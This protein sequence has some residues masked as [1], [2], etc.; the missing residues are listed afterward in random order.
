MGGR[1]AG[2]TLVEVLVVIGVIGVLIGLTLPAVQRARASASRVSCQNRLKQVGVALQN[3]HAAHGRLPPLPGKHSPSP[4]L[5][6]LLGWMAHIL[7]YID[8]D[9]LFRTSE[10]ACRTDPN[11]FHNPPHVGLA[12]IIPAYVCPDDGRLTPMTDSFGVTAAYTSYIGVNGAFVP[13]LGR[14]L[15]GPFGRPLTDVADGTSQ[16]LLVGERPPPDSLQA[17][18]WYPVYA[19][20]GEGFRGPNS[21]MVVNDPIMFAQDYEC[22][23]A[24]R[25]HFGPGR[26]DN[27]CDRYHFWSLHPGGA[28]WLFVD[29][30][31]R[32][33]AYSADPIIAALATRAGGETVEMPN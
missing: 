6:A 33:F 27:P 12:T 3:T 16:T 26:L 13:A 15:P 4:D 14:A 18:W 19:G 24:W 8:Q 17:G 7:P 20:S 23:G 11:P 29:G 1:R 30:S 28:N 21:F 9:A 25:G 5:Y 2:F 31:V 32:F 22:A 10:H